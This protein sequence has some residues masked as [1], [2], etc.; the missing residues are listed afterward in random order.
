MCEFESVHARVYSITKAF[1]A[2]TACVWF[3]LCLSLKVF[4]QVVTPTKVFAA[5]T[6]D[7][8]FLLYVS[9]KVL[10]RVATLTKQA[11]AAETACVWVVSYESHWCNCKLLFILM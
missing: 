9:L 11:F 4:M 1:T 5:L 6:A 7:V 3:F 2:L 10:I 8:R